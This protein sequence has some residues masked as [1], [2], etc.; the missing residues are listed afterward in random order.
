MN[1]TTQHRKTTHQ[2]RKTT[3]QVPIARVAVAVVAVGGLSGSIL[4]VNAAG[5]A[6]S[7]S[8][9]TVVVSTVKSTK[10]GKVLASGKTLYTL[11]AS[12]TPCTAACLKVWPELVLPKG[13]KKATAGS[14]VS[15]SKLGTVTRSG[16]VRQVTYGGKPLYWFVGDTANGQV[17][18]NISDEWGKWSAIVTAKPASGSSS[19]S[20]S[21]AT[22]SGSGGTAF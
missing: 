21:T 10:F 3:H 19:G 20:S 17:N 22:T 13:V 4:A 9:K 11:K 6:T 12:S 8:A 1:D 18:G 7:R 5:A 15:T 2:H 16:G 14:G